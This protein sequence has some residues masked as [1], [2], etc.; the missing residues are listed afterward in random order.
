VIRLGDRIATNPDAEAVGGRPAS[1]ADSLHEY[2]VQKGGDPLEQ[3]RPQ[4]A[5]R[6]LAGMPEGAVAKVL[7]QV[8]DVPA[9]GFGWAVGGQ[10]AKWASLSA[11][12]FR[13]TAGSWEIGGVTA[14][15][16]W[17]K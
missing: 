1:F 8:E 13:W 16:P 7:G 12:S 15:E 11:S 3:G 4:H 2:L 10:R 14:T 5:N 6:A 9:G 17:L